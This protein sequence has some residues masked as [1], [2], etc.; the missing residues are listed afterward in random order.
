M[1]NN[2]TLY[3][4]ISNDGKQGS[5]AGDIVLHQKAGNPSENEYSLS[6][7]DCIPDEVELHDEPSLMSVKS[8]TSKIYK[9]FVFDKFQVNSEPIECDYK[10]IVFIRESG[11]AVKKVRLICQGEK[12]RIDNKKIDNKLV[13]DA[14][15]KYLGDEAFT[16]QALEYKQDINVLNFIVF[17][18]GKNN[19]ASQIFKKTVGVERKLSGYGTIDLKNWSNT[20]FS[21]H[22]VQLIRKYNLNII[23]PL[24]EDWMYCNRK[25]KIKTPF[26]C[27]DKD[28]KRLNE[29]IVIFDKEFY[30]LFDLDESSKNTLWEFLLDR[31][32][33]VSE[34]VIICSN[35]YQL[36]GLR[37]PYEISI[38]TEV[39]TIE[40]FFKVGTLNYKK[41]FYNQ[42]VFQGDNVLLISDDGNRIIANYLYKVRFVKEESIICDKCEIMINSMYEQDILQEIKGAEIL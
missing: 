40:I 11:N 3:R 20:E 30:V 16:V 2:E 21:L 15:S 22:Y 6:Y 33:A 13:L 31:I 27:K 34:D 5:G 23:V 12:R 4:N 39:D 41:D 37:I 26:L 38:D 25:F 29:K 18:Y 7:F 35:E 32:D 17:L 42:K 1:L 19:K 36:K 10:F 14:V 8:D 9:V 24:L 28:N